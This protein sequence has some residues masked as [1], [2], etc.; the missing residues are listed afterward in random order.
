MRKIYLCV[1]FTLFS[2]SLSAYKDPVSGVEYETNSDGTAKVAS[3][4]LGKNL[5]TPNI[6]ILSSFSVGGKDYIVT[7]I[8][9]QQG[10]P[11]SV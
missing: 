6:V 1:L 4:N 3:D 5:K 2:L 7:E 8:S 11:V 10:F 9:G